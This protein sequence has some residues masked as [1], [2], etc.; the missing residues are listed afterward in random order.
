M[1]RS[2]IFFI[3]IVALCYFETLLSNR[4][5]KYLGWILPILTFVFTVVMGIM[6]ADSFSIAKFITTLIFTNI[7]TY[8]LIILYRVGR[9]RHYK[10][11]IK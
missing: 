4:D 8:I 10:N 2:L 11:S 3:I 9:G 7:P 5:N 6:W 1:E